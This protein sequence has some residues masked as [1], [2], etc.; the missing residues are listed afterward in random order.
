VAQH[1]T[2]QP[3]A[4]VLPEEQQILLPRG[5]EPSAK[6]PDLQGDSETGGAKSGA[7]SPVSGLADAHTPPAGGE[8]GQ[9]DL[10]QVIAAWP[11]LPE[12]I[13]AGILAMIKAS[14]GPSRQRT[15]ARGT[16]KTEHG[17]QP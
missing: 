13:K 17:G 2:Q 12:P 6:T 10:A 4:F 9:G 11:D 7:V 5:L 3:F 1:P 15:P 16:A 14:A 8:P